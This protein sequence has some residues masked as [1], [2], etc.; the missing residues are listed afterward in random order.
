MKSA[1][2]ENN[3]RKIDPPVNAKVVGIAESHGDGGGHAVSAFGTAPN[4][5]CSPPD[6]CGYL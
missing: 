3:L 4:Q 5:V 6:E 1:V 2:S